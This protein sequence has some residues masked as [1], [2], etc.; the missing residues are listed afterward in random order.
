VVGRKFAYIPIVVDGGYN[1]LGRRVKV[2]VGE[3][4]PTYLIGEHKLRNRMRCKNDYNF[5]SVY[6]RQILGLG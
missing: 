1:L 3:V 2:K 4:K 6:I 5:R